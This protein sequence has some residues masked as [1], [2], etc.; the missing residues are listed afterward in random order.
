[1]PRV[2][3]TGAA[4]QLGAAV[5]RRLV[6]EGHHVVALD[7]PGA[8]GRRGPRGPGIA[9]LPFDLTKTGLERHLDGIDAVAHLGGILPPRSERNP[10]LTRRVNK[11]GTRAL[12]QTLESVAPEARVVLASSFSVYGPGQAARGLAGEAS[13]TEATDAYTSSKLGAEALLRASTVDWTILRI[14]AA[15]EGS[16]TAIDPIALR[17][18]F[19]VDPEHPIELIHGDDAATA[20][21]RALFEPETSRRIL[22]IGGGARCQLRQRELMQLTLSLV[23]VDP[24][25]AE[26]HGR[27][28]YYT[29]WLDTEESQRLLDYQR[30]DPADIRDALRARLGARAPLARLAAP[31]VRRLLLSYSGPRRGDPP[32]PTWQAMIDA[33]F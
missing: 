18:M 14:A 5:V 21:A 22:P 24:I 31:L 13:P 1:M 11:E 2:L 17:L 20:I 10:A 7:L 16:A 19:E 6:A 4:G 30:H 33:G 8:L 12:V 9:R 32:R 15:I 3:V 23:G 27:A 29:C 28:P 26:A 25:P